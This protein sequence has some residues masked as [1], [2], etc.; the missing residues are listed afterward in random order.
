M[1]SFSSQLLLTTAASSSGLIPLADID[2]IKGAFKVYPD[3][4]TLQNEN[5]TFFTDKQ[6]VMTGDTGRLYQA[7]VTLADFI[8]VFEDSAS[9]TEFSFTGLT[10][11]VPDGTISG[12]LQIAELGYLTSASAAALGF[13]SGGGAVTDISALNSFTASAQISL[14]AL[15]S[16]TSSYA[17]KTEISGAFTSTSSSISTRLTSL[18]AGGGSVPDGTISGSQQITDLGFVNQSQTSSMSVLSSFTASY[19]DPTFISA[20]AAAAGFGSGGGTTTD[21]SALNTFTGSIQTQVDN[22]TAE[23]SSYLTSAD[24]SSFILVSQTSS[25]SVL[26]AL[27]ASYLIGGAGSIDTS[28]FVTN[29][30]T[31]SFIVVSQTSSMSVLSAETASFISDTFISASA[32]RSGFGTATLPSGVVSSSAQTIANLQGTGILSGSSSVPAG[33]ISGSQQ[34]TDLGFINQSQTS[35][36]SVATA[37]YVDPTF[38]SASAAA[39]GFGTAT[40]PSGVLSSS[41]QIAVEISGAFAEVS[42][43][44]AGRITTLEGTSGGD[45]TALNLF[46]SSIQTQVNNLTAETSSYL[47]SADTSSFVLNSQTASFIVVG[48]TSS[49]SVLNAVTASYIDPTFISASAAASGFGSGGGAATDISALNTF[50]ASIQTQVDNLTAETSSYLTSADTSSFIT[51]SQTSSMSVATASY[52]DPTFISA[53]AAAAGFGSGGGTIPAGTVSSSAQ[54]VANLVGQDVVVNSITAETY[55]ISSSVSFITTSFS[56]GSTR[57]GDT[58]NDTHIFTGSVSITGSLNIGG[59]FTI[60]NENLNVS[61]GSIILTNSSSIV[62]LDSGIIS[63]TFVGNLNYD[64]ITN[65]PNLISSS[66]QIALL[67]AGIISASAQ[68]ASDISGAFTSLSSS[69]ASR[70]AAL[71]AGSGG[72]SGIFTLTGSFYSTTNN[73][74]ITGSLSVGSGSFK[75]FEIDS[76]GFVVLGD[77]DKDLNNAPV[78]TI[79]YSG[80]SFYLIS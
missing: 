69:F 44:L 26:S 61:S 39:A 40:L 11:D 50:T 15:N 42:G 18:E 12:S 7:T 55:I 22:L 75:S 17:L 21:I 20:S 57:F 48:Q 63:G 80:S 71:E 13:G 34:I 10:A 43:G 32:A 27:T 41:A 60:N 49:M 24:T 76:D 53:S 74:Q 70:I 66:T 73:L 35:S 9:F 46:T 2:L 51:I 45:V 1:P 62:V 19:I 4:G 79:A 16:A 25:M 33:T 54:T 59:P 8:T 68:I 64:Y 28:S 23:T 65:L 3:L 6:V 14:T 47:T 38:I 78:G 67:G 52:I 72:G 77:M 56:S 30:Q 58:L 5:V 37:S 29:D 31:S 36:M